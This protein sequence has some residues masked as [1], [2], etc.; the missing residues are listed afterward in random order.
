MRIVLVGFGVVSRSFAEIIRTQASDLS[1]DYG[2]RPR[3]VGIVDSKGAATSADGI[4]IQT[5]LRSKEA[6]GTLDELGPN[7]YAEGKGALDVI[8]EVDCEVVVEATP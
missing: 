8:R 7:I 4:D 3:V 1:R 5:A 6:T 2:L